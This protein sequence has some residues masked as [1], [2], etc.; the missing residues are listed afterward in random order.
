MRYPT[1][2]PLG[3]IQATC[4][5]CGWKRL[6]SFYVLDGVPTNS[7]IML[8]SQVEA[9][10]FPRG[11]IHLCSCPKCA[12]VTNV[13]FDPQQVEYSQRYEETQSFSGTFNAFARSLAED[14]IERYDLH[15][16]EIA[17]IGCGKGEFLAL[18]CELGDNRGLGIDPG[19]RPARLKESPA[20]ARLQFIQEVY[21]P[22]QLSEQVDFVACR[23]V[24]EHIPD[25]LRFL[26][27]IRA[28]LG[29]REDVR[30][31]IEVRDL[32]KQ[33]Y[34]DHVSDHRGGSEYHR[35]LLGQRVHAVF[36][37]AMERGGH[38]KR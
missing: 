16:K 33:P 36:D 2:P 26:R 28:D 13:R 38:L 17:E 1:F 12:F 15:E 23:H 24:L 34:R 14:L 8:A 27:Q 18:L 35:V 25:P 19:C 21:A 6:H 5:S 30:V 29:D 32:L 3:P 10:E 22:G 4:P 9:L 20:G 7:C 11:V 31:L 37:E